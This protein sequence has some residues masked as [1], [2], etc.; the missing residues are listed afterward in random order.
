[1]IRMIVMNHFRPGDSLL[2][3]I[4]AEKLGL[5]RTPVSHALDRLLAEGFLE[6]RSKR[7]YF[8]PLPDPMDAEHVFSVRQLLEGEAAAEA[9]AAFRPEDMD[10]L[11]PYLERYVR[12]VFWRSNLYIFFFDGFYRNRGNSIPF[13][14]TPEQ[15]QRVL[16]AIRAKDGILARRLMQEHILY[17]YESM[18]SVL[19]VSAVT[20]GCGAD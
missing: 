7:G 6:K 13:Q 16:D 1:M 14:K 20:L 2:E 9:A 10:K 3:T 5:S 18:V 17:T 19:N 8:I 4:L 12:Q 15:H 11:D